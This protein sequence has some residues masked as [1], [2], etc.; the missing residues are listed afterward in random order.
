MSS[1][2]PFP[3]L[4]VEDRF[5]LKGTLEDIPQGLRTTTPLSRVCLAIL[6][7]WLVPRFTKVTFPLPLEISLAQM[8]V[9]EAFHL[10]L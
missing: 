9:E 7:P 5:H 4:I 3:Q 6:V 8:D 2:L 1:D 10:L